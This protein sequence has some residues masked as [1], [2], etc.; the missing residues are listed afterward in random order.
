MV[1]WPDFW[2]TKPVTLPSSVASG[3]TLNMSAE[4]CWAATRVM[5]RLAFGTVIGLGPVTGFVAA[6]VMALTTIAPTPW[7]AGLSF[8]LLGAGNL[9]IALLF[10]ALFV[11]HTQVDIFDAVMVG[12]GYEDLVNNRRV[13]AEDYDESDPVKRLGT[14]E[15]GAVFA[16]FSTPGFK[17]MMNFAASWKYRCNK[18]SCPRWLHCLAQLLLGRACTSAPDRKLDVPSSP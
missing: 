3:S 10:E 11:D 5:R 2:N 1:G 12:E 4:P 13:V 8:F 17:L 14:R 7:L 6:T 16:P 18:L 15:K 9:L